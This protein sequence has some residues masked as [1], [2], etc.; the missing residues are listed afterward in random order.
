MQFLDWSFLAVFFGD[1]FK[2]AC[3]FMI[4][5]RVNQCRVFQTKKSFFL[6]FFGFFIYNSQTFQK[7]INSHIINKKQK[8]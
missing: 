6:I 2:K 7:S 3:F 1:V 8:F 4:C 5:V